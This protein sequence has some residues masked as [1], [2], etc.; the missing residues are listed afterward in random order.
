M[1]LTKLILPSNFLLIYFPLELAVAKILSSCHV[2]FI[3]WFL[4]LLWTPTLPELFL[5]KTCSF[6]H[7]ENFFFSSCATSLI[8]QLWHPTRQG[9]LLQ[10]QHWLGGL[11]QEHGDHTAL[12][13]RRTP[14]SD[15]RQCTR[16]DL[17]HSKA[18]IFQALDNLMVEFFPHSHL[19]LFI[20]ICQMA[21]G[22]EGLPDWVIFSEKSYKDEGFQCAF[23]MN[24]KSRAPG[25]TSSTCPPVGVGQSKDRVRWDILGAVKFQRRVLHLWIVSACFRYFYQH[26][27]LN[28]Y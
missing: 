26:F 16:E 7:L 3:S 1:F 24:H 2:D 13:W 12:A 19:A 18:N 10:R 9:A 22:L 4:A 11:S 17:H 27:R 20:G 23:S 28:S 25:P 8:P 15:S 21:L 14:S 6:A 5:S